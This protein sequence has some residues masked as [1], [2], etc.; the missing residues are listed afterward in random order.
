MLTHAL[1]VLRVI[2]CLGSRRTRE[3]SF[4]QPLQS[5]GR[6][7]EFSRRPK[8]EARAS[9]DEM[10]VALVNKT[11]AG[12]EMTSLRAPA[13][14]IFCQSN[15]RACLH[16]RE[17]PQT[18]SSRTGEMEPQAL[19]SVIFTNKCLFGSC[20]WHLFNLKICERGIFTKI[21]PEFGRPNTN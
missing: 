15:G 18:R 11:A 14:E 6:K 8:E 19:S 16:G 1:S 13:V 10:G 9:L 5:A 7:S 12:P 4:L 21:L 3:K 17:L 2:V 20:L